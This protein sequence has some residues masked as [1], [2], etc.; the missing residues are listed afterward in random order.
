MIL[1]N[2]SETPSPTISFPLEGTKKNDKNVPYKHNA[3]SQVDDA[4]GKG[5]CRQALW[6]ERV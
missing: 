1:S 4:P 3:Y 6:H 2:V 5:T